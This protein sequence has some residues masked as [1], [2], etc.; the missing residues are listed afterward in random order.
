MKLAD[1]L[2]GRLTAGLLGT[3]DLEPAVVPIPDVVLEAL[4]EPVKPRSPGARAHP[5]LAHRDE[6]RRQEVGAEPGSWVLGKETNPCLVYPLPAF[7]VLQ[8]ICRCLDVPDRAR[9][10]AILLAIGKAAVQLGEG[11]KKYSF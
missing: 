2:R 11:R 4:D 10:S 9:R 1:G 3:R 6:D 5:G 7:V 8:G